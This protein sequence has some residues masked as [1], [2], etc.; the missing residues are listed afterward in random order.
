V[1]LETILLLARALAVENRVPE[2]AELNEALQMPLSLYWG[3]VLPTVSE[4]AAAPS[5]PATQVVQKLQKMAG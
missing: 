3:E 2:P 1:T 5:S 4:F